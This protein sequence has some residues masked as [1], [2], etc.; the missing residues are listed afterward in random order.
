[1]SE[2]LVP[3]SI[4]FPEQAARETRSFTLRENP[5]LP[6]DEYGLLEFYCP[7]PHC[8]CR[9]VMLNVMSRQQGAV[10]AAINF[11]FQRDGEFAGPFLDPL[12]RQSIHAEALL[13][14]VG[15]LLA[16]TLYVARLEAHYYQ[17]K[18]AAADPA[19]PG[20]QRLMEAE[21][22]E[23]KAGPPAGRARRTMARRN[24]RGKPRGR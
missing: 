2:G 11:G 20:H 3:F 23:S 9:R 14:V 10:V 13:A 21:Q 6:A 1:V 18:G 19:H 8:P 7:D 4:F 15:D 22:R 5:V 24:T 16:D 12:N 17:I